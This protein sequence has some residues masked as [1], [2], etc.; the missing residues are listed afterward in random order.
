MRTEP[1]F[2][3]SRRW[4]A[5]C[6]HANGE[7]KAEFHLLRQ[8][9]DVYLPRYLKLV[10][11]ARR[12]EY[13]PRPLFPRYLFVSLREDDAWRPIQSTVGVTTLVFSGDRPAFLSEEIIHEIRERENENGLVRIN[14]GRRFRAGEEVRVE[15]GSFSGV[16]A[17][18]ASHDD[19]ERVTVLLS[20]LGG[21]VKAHL[22][23]EAIRALS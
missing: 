11:H 12:Q 6:T 13:L 23:L 2:D 8:N 5:V 4:A 15:T 22:P 1:D 14:Y 19:S 18:F 21:Q 3:G 7:N 10:R 16:D 17:I 20:I 9:Y